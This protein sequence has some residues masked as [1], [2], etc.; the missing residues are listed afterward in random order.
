MV[1][2]DA[3]NGDKKFSSCLPE[4]NCHK[5]RLTAD[6][7]CDKMRTIKIACPRQSNLS[8]HFYFQNSPPHSI[9][10]CGG[11][12]SAGITGLPSLEGETCVFIA[13]VCGR[14]AGRDTEHSCIRL[15]HIAG[16]LPA[17]ERAL[18]CLRF[19]GIAQPCEGGVLLDAGVFGKSSKERT[20]SAAVVYRSFEAA[21]G[22]KGRLRRALFP[23]ART[24]KA[25]YLYA[26]RHPWLLPVAWAHRFFNY[27]LARLTGRATREE[28]SEGMRIAGERLRLLGEL[29]MRG[30]AKAPK[31]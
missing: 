20:R 28:G 14:R 31:K 26:R 5:M 2:E 16:G 15:L 17:R 8:F 22:D 11:L 7:V 13:D 29:G 6:T 18:I 9:A 19:G 25:P 12:F 3:E 1:K 21:D 4:P 23:S 27:A 30:G 24:L 10:L